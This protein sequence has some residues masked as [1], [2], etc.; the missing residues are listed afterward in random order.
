MANML[1]PCLLLVLLLLAP[2]L[3]AP[4]ERGLIFNLVRGM[5][6]RSLPQPGDAP[7]AAM[8]GSEGSA[9]LWSLAAAT[10][11]SPGATAA[12]AESKTYCGW[13]N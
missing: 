1:S 7:S 11:G 2:A 12:A 6:T 13:G 8:G 5:L 9:V 3:S 4:H 10:R